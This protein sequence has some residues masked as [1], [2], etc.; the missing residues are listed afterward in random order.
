MTIPTP[1]RGV[2]EVRAELVCDGR[3]FKVEGETENRV[4]K[5]DVLAYTVQM[6]PKS[7]ISRKSITLVYYTFNSV[8]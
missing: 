8:D 4:H 6:W 5:S 1:Q 3:S 2:G 7:C